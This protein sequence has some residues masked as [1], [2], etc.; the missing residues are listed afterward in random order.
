MVEIILYF[1]GNRV[2]RELLSPLELLITELTLKVIIS[3]VFFLEVSQ[4]SLL[5]CEIQI[6]NTTMSQF[7]RL[8]I[9]TFD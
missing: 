9:H 7:E 1:T 5:C 2:V 8:F 6:T 4:Q 3:F